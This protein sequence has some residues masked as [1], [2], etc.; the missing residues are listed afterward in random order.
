LASWR[1]PDRADAQP[2][3]L[4]RAGSPGLPVLA[5]WRFPD[6]AD[7]QPRY[8]VRAGS[9]GLPMPANSSAADGVE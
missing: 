7:A 9:P 1:F 5:S 6:R 2:R 3:H 4:V 8:L